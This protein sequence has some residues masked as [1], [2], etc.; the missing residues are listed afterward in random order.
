MD[1]VA[2]GYVVAAFLLVLGV[3]H[4]WAASQPLLAGREPSQQKSWLRKVMSIKATIILYGVFYAVLAF[5][6]VFT[7]LGNS[8]FLTYQAPCE[9]LLANQTVSGNTTIFSYADSCS[10]MEP[11]V[12]VERLYVI[13]GWAWGIQLI[14]LSLGM[15]IGVVAWLIRW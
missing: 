11:P 2:S 10:T 8:L 9:Q 7:S 14:L 1:F 12:T 5:L 3:A 4:L 6:F 15:F 13:L